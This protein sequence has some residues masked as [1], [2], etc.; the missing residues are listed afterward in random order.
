MGTSFNA[1]ARRNEKM[2]IAI[3]V[4]LCCFGSIQSNPIKNIEGPIEIIFSDSF[5]KSV[6]RNKNDDKGSISCKVTICIESNTD[7]NAI[8]NRRKFVHCGSNPLET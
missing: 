5:A 8:N 6:N 1:E 3:V 4:P 7:N 2:F